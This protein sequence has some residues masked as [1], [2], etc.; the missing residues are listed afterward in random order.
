MSLVELSWRR[1]R[2]LNDIGYYQGEADRGGP[3]YEP[4]LAELRDQ[5]KEINEQIEQEK[6]CV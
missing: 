2:I 4:E 6:Q 5:L 3:R 1:N